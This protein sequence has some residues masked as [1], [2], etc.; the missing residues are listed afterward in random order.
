MG[1]I[2]FKVGQFFIYKNPSTQKET[3]VR[4]VLIRG[5]LD[6]LSHVCLVSSEKWEYRN[7]VDPRNLTP[8]EHS[9]LME[10]LDSIGS[11]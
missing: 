4:L 6:G 9:D 11:L 3:I 5:D 8:C 2:K 1:D 10:E 7:W